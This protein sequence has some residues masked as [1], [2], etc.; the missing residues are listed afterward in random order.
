M[1]GYGAPQRTQQAIEARERAEKQE[2]TD[3]L[4]AHADEVQAYHDLN[5]EVP[6]TTNFG[7]IDM[8]TMKAMI[9]NAAAG[10]VEGVSQHWLGVHDQL[11]GSGGHGT[12]DC[13]HGQL[14]KAVDNVMEHWEGE[15]A[16]T[17]RREADKIL[18]QI[19]NTASHAKAVS[20][21]MHETS[22]AIGTQQ[23]ALSKIKKPSWLSSAWDSLTDSGRS[24]KYTQKEV[25][26]K[27]L[28][29]D[30]LAQ[31]HED[32]LSAGKETQ[33][34]AAAVMEKLARHYVRTG[35]HLGSLAPFDE[36]HEVPPAN[37]AIPMPAPIPPYSGSSATPSS[38]VPS[39]KAKN[40]GTIPR[41]EEYL[42]PRDGGI[43]GGKQ[44]PVSET[45]I[46]GLPG[47]FKGHNN[48]ESLYNT[49]LPG[50][51]TPG[52]GHMQTPTLPGGPPGGLPGRGGGQ[53]RAGG[54]LPSSR[55]N[56]RNSGIGNSNE[57]GTGGGRM[58][59]MHGGGGGAKGGRSGSG[60]RGPLAR[61]KGGIAG[62]PK[63]ITGGKAA[64]P[65]GTG[66]GKGRGGRGIFAGRGANQR[67]GEEEND[68]GTRPDYL[69]EDEETWTP[70]DG[71]SVPRN[72]E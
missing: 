21:A 18:R 6:L 40:F 64:T 33:L 46:D 12:G 69:V 11:M 1:A 25:E 8:D 53:G 70:E 16:N 13:A 44:I 54:G 43:T 4:K 57:R 36:R 61:A 35:Q 39:T 37:P 56:V 52:G 51:T 22:Q 32:H 7:N 65:G 28:P 34:Q 55:T 20:N 17:F 45:N 48:Q 38:S 60:G 31:I 62:A 68:E 14:K 5:A 42:G 19:A 71:R 49:N 41:P 9:A 15:S 30:V 50:R 47:G 66:L 27:T 2:D 10:N 63:G 24:D 23:D 72:I 59:G 29:P 26:N 3:G 67:P 58:G